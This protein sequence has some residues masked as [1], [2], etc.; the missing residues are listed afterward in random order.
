MS[1][2]NFLHT[3][4]SRPKDELLALSETNSRKWLIEP[5]LQELGW[6]TDRWSDVREVIEEYNIRGKR[7][8]YCLQIEGD[9]KVFIEAKKPNVALVMG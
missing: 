6:N 1:L 4:Q 3:L 7:V 8:D 9:N 5:V 2:G